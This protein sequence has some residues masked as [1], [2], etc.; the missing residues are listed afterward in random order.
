MLDVY[1]RS[2]R[3]FEG[4]TTDESI[5]NARDSIRFIYVVSYSYLDLVFGTVI[6]LYN[7]RVGNK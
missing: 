4:P 6:H 5:L 3:S 2:H 7:K 1:A